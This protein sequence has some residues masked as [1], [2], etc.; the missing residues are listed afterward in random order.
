MLGARVVVTSR[1]DHKLARARELG[2][3]AGIDCTAT[4]DWP[5]A[6]VELTGGVGADYVV[7]TVGELKDAIAAVRLG[8]T[9]AFV[10][11]LQGMTAEIDLVAFMGKCARVEAVDVGSREMFEAMNKAL[12]FH[13]VR[14]VVDRVFGFN[15]VG[16]ALTYL[17]SGRHVGKVCLR[18]LFER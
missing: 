1:S 6:V 10:G 7:D 12:D 11:L 8:G 16:A 9:V 17:S 5:G 14:P 15:E 2:A 4:P 3:A 18:A 13:A